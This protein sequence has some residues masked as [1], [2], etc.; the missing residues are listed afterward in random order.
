[1]F[2]PSKCQACGTSYIPHRWDQ[3]HCS[4]PCKTLGSNLEQTRGR[5]IYGLALRWRFD[6]KN[7]NLYLKALCRLL[8]R[9]HEEDEK[10]GR[11]LPHLYPE[12]VA[13]MDGVRPVAAGGKGLK[14]AL[15]DATIG[16]DASGTQP[17]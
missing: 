12:Q 11:P 8:A 2:K 7:S 16:N 13:L 9:F 14:V 3:R 4:R 6:R 10:L 15:W 17:L 1:M 5:Q